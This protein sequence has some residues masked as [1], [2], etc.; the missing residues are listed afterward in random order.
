MQGS[1]PEASLIDLQGTL[2]LRRQ[3]FGYLMTAIVT[4]LT[5]LALV[6]LFAV[7]LSI[8]QQGLPQLSWQTLTSLPA[9]MGMTDVTNGIANAIVGTVVIVG[10]ASL[11]SIPFGVMTAIYLAEFGQSSGLAYFVRFI[12][13]ILSG[14]PSIVVGVFAYGVIVLSTK[15]FS[16]WAG[17]FALAIIMLPIVTLS[18]ES[19]LLLV[20]SSQRLASAAL[21]GNPFQTTWRIVLKTALPG[22]V[23][24]ILLAIA[25]A[26]GE[27]APLIFTALSSDNWLSSLNSPTASLSVLIYNYANSPFPEQNAMGWTAALVLLAVILTINIFSRLVTRKSS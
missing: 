10:M 18:T 13:V 21:G 4:S 27:T 20:P 16:A 15:E 2:P 6:P 8:L 7:L 12:I 14:V 24:G 26:A 9:P 22:I 25:R 1:I 19:A 3:I 5:A 11:I 23:T 17:S